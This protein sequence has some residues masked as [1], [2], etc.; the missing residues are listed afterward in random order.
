MGQACGGA[1]VLG[2]SDQ[3]LAVWTWVPS[4]FFGQY[5][6]SRQCAQSA[7]CGHTAPVAGQSYPGVYG[8]SAASSAWIGATPATPSGCFRVDAQ[9]RGDRS[10]L[11]S[12]LCQQCWAPPTCDAGGEQ[13]WDEK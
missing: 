4:L 1:Y 2:L 7:H 13:T 11:P 6:T 9:S 12:T 8:G 3:G 5:N 10:V